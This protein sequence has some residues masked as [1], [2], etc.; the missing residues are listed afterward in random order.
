MKLGRQAGQFQVIQPELFLDGQYLTR[1][2]PAGDDKQPVGLIRFRFLRLDQV[3]PA[4]ATG[5]IYLSRETPSM[6]PVLAQLERLL[7]Q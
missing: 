6:A 5:L 3:E 1:N 7:S 2:H 4:F